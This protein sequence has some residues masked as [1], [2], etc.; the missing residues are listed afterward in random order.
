MYERLLNKNE[1][2][3]MESLTAYCGEPG[4]AFAALSAWL[5]KSYDTEQQLSFPY[6]NHYGWCIAHRKKK[7][8]IC[9]I[10]A[11]NSAFA[12]MM[13]LSD[14]QYASVYYNLCAHT[15]KAIDEKYPC[16]DGGWICYRVTEKAH[17]EDIKVLLGLKF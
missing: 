15:Q 17:F 7:K 11:E 12:V 2:Q 8:L 3:T 1:P 10:F 4:E 6:G 13:H 9:N 5:S 14:Q 16:G